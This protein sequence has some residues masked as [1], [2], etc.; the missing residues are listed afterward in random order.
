MDDFRMVEHQ[1][2]RGSFQGLIGLYR[3]DRVERVIRQSRRG[4]KRGLR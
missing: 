2:D 4:T 1:T 3:D